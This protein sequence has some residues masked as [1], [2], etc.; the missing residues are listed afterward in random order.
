MSRI[1][2]ITYFD[3]E[4]LKKVSKV[5]NKINFNMCKVPYGINDSKR[6]KIDNLPYHFTIFATNKKNQASLLKTAQQIKIKDI[7]LEINDVK[8]MDGKDNSYVLY[9]SIKE[10]ENIKTL[11]K[12]FYERIKGEENYN[13]DKFIFH[14]TLHIDK[15]KKQILELLEKIKLDFKPFSL[16][17]NK[18]AL[19]DY[20]G[21]IIE[22]INITN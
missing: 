20:P 15:D 6:Y 4:N 19:F 3:D 10:N 21:D 11:Q 1:T 13:P 12:I 22:I 9:F 17:L 16:E 18:L 8:I 2:L 7:K 5:M 14:M